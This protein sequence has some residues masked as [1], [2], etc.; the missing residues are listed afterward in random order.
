MGQEGSEHACETTSLR[1]GENQFT[2]FV[3]AS[4]VD[5]KLSK[6]HGDLM[7][8]IDGKA[9]APLSFEKLLISAFFMNFTLQ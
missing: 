5:E 1:L 8:L 7:D 3:S 9:I 6:D 2:H 4:N